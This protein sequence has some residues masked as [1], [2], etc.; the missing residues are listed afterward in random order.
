M[1]DAL[2]AIWQ[3]VLRLPSI[4][5]NDNFFDLGGDSALALA[6]FNEIAKM[7]G[8]DLPPVMIY[9]APTIADLAALLEQPNTP[10]LPPL[11]LLKDGIEDMPIFI[12]HGLGGSVMDFYQVVKHIE[13]PL[14]IYG[15]QARGI[16]GVEEPFERIEDM[17]QFY[18]DAIQKLQPSGPYILIGYSLGGLVTLEMAQRLLKKNEK[19]ALLTMLDAYPHMRYLPLGQ[20]VSRIARK[21]GQRASNLMRFSIGVG[22]DTPYQVPV[23]AP[24]TPVMKH[25]RDCAYLA[26][27][28]YEPQFYPGKIS[29]VRADIATDFPSNATAVWSHLA[30]EFEVQTVPGDHLGIMTT[31]Y[32]N[33]ASVLSDYLARIQRTI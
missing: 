14:A 15:M 28:R 22:S 32:E 9:E 30:D 20:R 33:L 5:V 7:Y 21:T 16:D 19:V 13:S 17:A 26:L 2:T 8:R 23:G 6:L 25:V 29:F 3:R 31:Y 10:R 24:S 4:S 18:L 1:I 11:F 27:Q 12:T